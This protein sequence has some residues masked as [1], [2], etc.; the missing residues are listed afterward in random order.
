MLNVK[1]D[2]SNILR[3]FPQLN[4]K[5]KKGIL[6][7]LVKTALVDIETPAKQ[8]VRVDTGRLR[9]SIHT[10][11]M[12]HFGDLSIKPTNSLQVIVG[13]NVEYAVYVERRYP[14]LFPAFESSRSALISRI[15]DVI[16]TL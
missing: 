3:N 10:E 9:A 8:N 2:T 1:F 16:K 4:E 15:S 13:T 5:M 7:A 12:G 6:D 14:F 11:Y